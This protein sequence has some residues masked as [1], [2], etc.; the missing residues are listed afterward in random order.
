MAGADQDRRAATPNRV[1]RG[2]LP[3]RVI[4]AVI[5]APL[6]IGAAYVGGWPFVLFCALAAVGIWWEWAALSAGPGARIVMAIGAGALAAATGF[7]MVSWIAAAVACLAIG[8]L[9]VAAAAPP[10]ARGWVA[11]GVLYAGAMLVAPVVLRSDP[12][13]GFLAIVL[14]FAVVW[15]TDIVAYFAGRAVGGPKLAPRVSPNKTWAGALGG[16]C[17]AVIAAA[18]VA[19]A[20]KPG[21]GT[22]LVLV[23]L[24]LSV[25]SQVGDLFESAVKRRYGAKNAGQLIPGHGGLMDRLDGF[26]AAALVAA[27]LG[28]VRG[29]PDASARG[30]L[31]W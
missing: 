20:A 6:A 24:G 10:N 26:I 22:A 9:A 8:A 19:A 1:G 28:L 16:A 18:T 13:E 25:A 4:S 27:I 29:G 2:E 23:G 17:G 12:H 15:A 11:L 14:L 3:I 5:L 31:V 7:L 21:H 30:L